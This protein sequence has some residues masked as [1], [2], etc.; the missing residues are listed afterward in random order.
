M[1]LFFLIFYVVRIGDI[2]MMW[3]CENEAAVVICSYCIYLQQQV[4]VED[5]ESQPNTEDIHT[6]EEQNQNPIS[7]NRRAQ[8]SF[9]SPSPPKGRASSSL[10]ENLLGNTFPG[11]TA[12]Q[13]PISAYA[14]AEE[15]VSKFC[16]APP[17]PL[18][19]EHL[20]WWRNNHKALVIDKMCLCFWYSLSVILIEDL[21]VG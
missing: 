19:E 11:A 16:G 17:I 13:Q 2:D 20:S 15:E 14:K 10:L 21:D 9:Q 7:H 6:T 12:Q 1:I 18:S 4:R 5:E 3:K 8:S